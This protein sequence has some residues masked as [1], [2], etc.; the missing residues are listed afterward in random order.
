MRAVTDICTPSPVVASHI[1]QISPG[2][3]QPA[4]Y[5]PFWA[6]CCSK[7]R[8]IGP[9]LQS[10][11][12]HPDGQNGPRVH[13]PELAPP[14]PILL[15]HSMFPA[16]RSGSLPVVSW[17]QSPHIGHLLPVNTIGTPVPTYMTDNPTPANLDRAD[18]DNAV[19]FRQT[20]FTTFTN[21]ASATACWRAGGW[22]GV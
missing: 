21:A 7:P 5:F 17:Q 8:V 6:R 2:H 9:S 16:T 18:A 13:A 20:Q 10:V 3:T 12:S 4:V 14:P 15:L 22:Y 11:Q 19:P 1:R